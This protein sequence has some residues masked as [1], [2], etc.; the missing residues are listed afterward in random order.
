MANDDMKVITVMTR[1]G[2]AGKTTLIRA[3]ISAAMQRGKRCLLID[4]DPQQ[5]L[6]RWTE[7]LRIEDPLFTLCPRLQAAEDLARVVEDSYEAGETD[8]VFIDTIGAAGDWADILA[9]DS[10][11]LVVPMMLSDDDLEITKDTF[12]WY[13]G[14]RQRA[15]DPELLP[16]FHVVLSNVPSK[17]SKAE[18]AVEHQAVQVF[19]VVE[20][21]FM[22]RKQHKDASSHGFLHH[23]AAEKRASLNPLLRVHAKHYDEALEEAGAILDQVER[24]S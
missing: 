12:N 6:A 1:K 24:A 16:S 22:S 8:Y 10:D 4:T 7:K 5:A 14:M 17:P 23:L 18:E 2:G 20:D 19:P 9:I 3:L 13:V 15:D 11:A 21:Y